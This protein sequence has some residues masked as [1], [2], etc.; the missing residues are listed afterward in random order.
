M[1]EWQEFFLWQ[2][3][4]HDLPIVEHCLEW[5]QLISFHLEVETWPLIFGIVPSLK[6][7]EDR[8]DHWP[9]L[10]YGGRKSTSQI[11]FVGRSC[12]IEANVGILVLIHSC[13]IIKIKI[14]NGN[15]NGTKCCLIC[16][17]AQHTRCSGCSAL[18]IFR[19]LLYK[20]CCAPP[21]F[22]NSIE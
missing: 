5:Y 2:K 13:K 21:I 19:K 7:L 11:H 17:G 9:R 1:K 4:C 20:M 12:W 18:P 10:R 8:K 15:G 3:V 22:W 16:K 6:V 14:W